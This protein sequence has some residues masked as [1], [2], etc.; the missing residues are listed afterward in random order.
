[1]PDQDE[2]FI[3]MGENTQSAADPE[4]YDIHDAAEA[5]A[6]AAQDK[7]HHDLWERAMTLAGDAWD[8]DLPTNTPLEELRS[9]LAALQE[10]AAAVGLA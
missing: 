6:T 2:D 4:F 7:G 1:M 8:P 9:R 3:D 5:I 10:E